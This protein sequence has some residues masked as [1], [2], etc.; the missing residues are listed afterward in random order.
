METEPVRYELMGLKFEDWRKRVSRQ[1]RVL[2]S[3]VL[4]NAAATSPVHVDSVLA[5]DSEYFLYWGQGKAILKGLP[6]SVR[7]A[8]G[9]LTGDFKWGIPEMEQRKDVYR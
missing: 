2:A 8:D 7:F 3:N 9:T 5:Y 1:P 6:T 4:S